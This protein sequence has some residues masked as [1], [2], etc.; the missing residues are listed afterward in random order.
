MRATVAASL[1]SFE[2]FIELWRQQ[3][4]PALLLVSVD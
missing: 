4:E 2:S 3:A 1:E